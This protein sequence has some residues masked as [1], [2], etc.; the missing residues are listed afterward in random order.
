MLK[1]IKSQS[2]MQRGNL[3]TE[4]VAPRTAW[5]RNIAAIWCDVLGLDRV[6]IHDS[7]FELGG[8][9]LHAAEA[10]ACMWE[11]GVPDSISLINIPEPT[12]SMLCQ[13]IEDV[14]AGRKPTLITDQFSLAD[15]GKLP[16]DIHHY[17]YDIQQYDTPM[18]KVFITGAT[19]Y[20]GASLLSELFIQTH[21]TVRCLV[22]AATKQDAMQR[23][24]QNLASYGLWKEVYRP[25]LSV[26][27]GELSEPNMG[28][29][30]SQFNAIGHE[31]DTI[32]HSAAWVNFV[33]PYQ[34][35]KPSHIDAMETILRLCVVAK[36]KP[37][38]LHFISTLGVIMSTGY[39]KSDIVMEDAPLQHVEGLL[40]G[41]EQAKHVAD[42]M[43]FEAMQRGIPTAIYRPGMVGGFSD[44]GEY[45]K[46]DE[47]LSSFY[48]GCI[49][50]GSWPMLDTTWEVVPVD[51]ICKAIIHGAKNCANLNQA[52]FTLHPE[53]TPV[54]D[55][56]Q[57]FQ[58]YGYPMR[59]L[60]WDIWKRE[61]ISQGTE[62]LKSNALFPFIDFIRALD[63]EQVRFPNTNRDNF[64]RLV[65]EANL[66]VPSQLTILERYIQYFIRLGHVPSP[67]YMQ[68]K[69]VA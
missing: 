9:S 35:L 32:F 21:V 1:K 27:L 60:P 47:F 41:Y 22:R 17:G 10:F 51:F 14:K 64:N 39:S 52:Y 24:I 48:K 38:A 42:K 11:L 15:E 18:N 59:A 65:K 37:I 61:L 7:F 45:H 2:K 4:F 62:K 46:K 26:T 34:Q 33:F 44:T 23:V 40:N 63:N 30:E 3:S 31:I 5:H 29:S 49:Q 54:A 13:A 8:D 56:I 57:W 50:L 16:N 28:L 6:G 19:G 25:R 66:E 58:R 69:Q 43:A 53:P 12:V 20:L 68:A 67:E 36:P 55:Y